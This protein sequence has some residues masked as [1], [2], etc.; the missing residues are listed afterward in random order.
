MLDEVQI[1]NRALDA[2]EI[3]DIWEAGSWG[4]CKLYCNIPR[5]VPFCPNE[6][7]KTVT[8][9]LYNNSNQLANCTWTVNPSGKCPAGINPAGFGVPSFVPTSGTI[10]VPANSSVTTT[11]DITKPPS[12]AIG[13]TWCYEVAIT[14]AI[15]GRTFSCYGAGKCVNNIN[16]P[17]DPY[18]GPPADLQFAGPPINIYFAIE[19]TGS[20][21]K[22]LDYTIRAMPSG[23]CG[24]TMTLYYIYCD[25]LPGVTS[26]STIIPPGETDT[27]TAEIELV[28]NIGGRLCDI[29]LEDDFDGDGSVEQNMSISVHL[30]AIADCNENGIDD[31]DDI[32][33]ETS[34][35]LNAN[36]VPDECEA[37]DYAKCGDANGDYTCNVGDAVFLITYVFKGGPAP[38]PLASGDANADC[39]CNVGDAV[40]VINYVFKGGDPPICD[41]ICEWP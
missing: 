1:F 26:G 5:I 14:D 13:D 7:T 16:C 9:T 36:G 38:D 11:I 33:D 31:Q 2:S 29:V 28:A 8:L 15:T 25:S 39:N 27:V 12:C 34:V 3:F 32:N 37:I 18:P 10:P 20:T 40:Y 19:N 4:K 22:V 30:K 41:D 23:C 17:P 6:N 21:D 35:D 24:D